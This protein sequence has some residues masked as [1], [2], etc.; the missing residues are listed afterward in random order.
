MASLDDEAWYFAG[1]GVPVG[2]K[3]RAVGFRVVLL[4]LSL[5][6]AAFA[7]FWIVPGAMVGSVGKWVGGLVGK[8]GLGGR[9][10][11]DGGRRG[12]R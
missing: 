10:T 8:S 1:S 12:R 3:E 11:E 6:L 9:G 4:L 7:S 5:P 2:W